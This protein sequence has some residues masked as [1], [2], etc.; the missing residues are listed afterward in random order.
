MKILRNTTSPI[1]CVAINV[2]YKVTST[3]TTCDKLIG[4]VFQG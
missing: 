3:A 1:N 4:C 2:K